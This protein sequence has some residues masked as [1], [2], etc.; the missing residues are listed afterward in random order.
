MQLFLVIPGLFSLAINAYMFLHACTNKESRKFETFYCYGVGIVWGIISPVMS[1]A[2]FT[3]VA[4][5]GGCDSAECAGEGAVCMVY[6]ASPFLVQVQII[7]REMVLHRWEPTVGLVVEWR[8]LTTVVFCLYPT[9]DANHGGKLVCGTLHES[10]ID[11]A[12]D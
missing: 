1:A 8:F 10:Q 3:D 6:K 4:C 9:V 2:L 12:A 11:V 5:N 7:Y